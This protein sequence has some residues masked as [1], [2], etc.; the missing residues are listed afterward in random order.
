MD[1]A[2]EKIRPHTNSNLAHQKA[3]ANLLAAVESTFSEQ[4]TDPSP[5]A[6]FAALLT[7]LDST[8]QKRDVSLGDGDILPA[9]LYLLALVAPFVPVPVMRSH[10]NTVLTLTA[11]LFPALTQHAP[12]L[13]SQLSLYNAVLRALDR[14]QLDVQSIRQAFASILQLCIDPR[15]KVRK[16][17]AD[18]V[19]D[20]LESPPA[21]LSRHPYSERV[22][23]W[24]KSALSEANIV[25]FSRAKP[26]KTSGTDSAIHVLAFLRP[27]LPN[28]PASSLP[29]ISNLL[30]SLPR[31][32]NPYLSQSSYSILSDLFALPVEDESIGVNEQISDVLNAVLSSPPSKSDATLSPAWVRVLGTA[33][34]TYSLTDSNAASQEIGRVWKAVFS[35]LESS[36]SSTRTAAAES[37][38]RV[39]GC[40]TPSMIDSALAETDHRSTLGKI[41]TQVTK[42]LNSL[43]YANAIPQ[44]LTV[45]AELILALRYKPDGRTTGAESLLLPLIKHIGDLRIQKG[46]EFKEDAD[47]TL[48]AAMRVL[49]PHVLLGV[50]PLNLEPIDRQEGREP[51][52]YLLPLL[53]QPH[54]SP[55][56]HFVSYFVPL[57]ER[58]FALQQAAEA[59]D[60]QSQAKLWSVL[61]GQIW[62]GLVG[63]CWAPTALK[64]SLNATFSSL[65]S[66]LLYGQAE[67]RPS[68]LKALRVIV[69]SNVAVAS[70][71]TDPAPTNPSGLSPAQ[72]SD[73]VA[74]LRTQAE[75]WLAVLFNVFGT[76]GRD[77]RAVVGDVISAWA[78]VAGEKEIAAAQSKIV[79]LLK[80]NLAAQAAN[81]RHSSIEGGSE[82][83]TTQ[84]LVLLLLPYIS[85]ADAQK[86]FQ[87]CL[88]KTVLCAKDN[89][90]QKRGYKILTR[91]I[92]T[93]KVSIEVET[94]LK[95]LDET[96]EGITPAAKKDRFSLLALLVAQLPSSA[97]H[98]IPS[99]IPEAVLGTKEP[100]EKARDAAFELI[101]DMGKKM[102]QGGVVKRSLVD[103]MEEDGAG[104]TTANIQEFMTMVAGG[105]AGAS[106]HMISATVTAISRLVFEFKDSIPASMH[107]E[108][109]STLF[110]FISSANREIV[111]SILGFVKLA[112]HSLPADLVRPHLPTLVPALLGWSHDHKNHFKVKVRHIFERML[113]RFGWNEVYGYAGEDEAKKVLENIKKRKER[114]KRKKAQA[115]EDEDE[116]TNK[117][118]TG[119]AFEDVLYGSESE[120][121]DSDD[122]EPHQ[123]QRSTGKRRGGESGA[124][125]RIDDDEPMDL[126]QGAASR[127]TQAKSERR[128]KPG[129][130]AARFKT[131]EETGKMLIDGDDDDAE[132]GEDADIAGA[133]YR[134]N[135]TSVDGFTRGANGR[136]KFN[137]DTKKRRRENEDVDGDVEMGDVEPGGAPKSA[138]KAKGRSEAKFGHEFKA[139]KAGGDIKRGGVD[140]YAYM[141]LSQAAKRK[142]GK[143]DKMGIVGK[144]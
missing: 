63:Y 72:A 2:L 46:F 123:Q 74:Y 41:I 38:R 35:Y 131:D 47:V 116:P 143:R 118:A 36:D 108:I 23:D 95:E 33:M 91:L 100:S 45:I 144:R 117:Q 14:S 135:L 64:E 20:V 97:L 124:R 80:N 24:I 16:K 139:K 19:K 52:A 66:G 57:S 48:S 115:N 112:I 27:I 79:Q 68:V 56:S 7:T 110:V 126:L 138:K 22:A 28:L 53:P 31:L 107:S 70:G 88:S 93:K 54:P 55:L 105:L 15:P 42:E 29:A 10:L 87:L 103:G 71:A 98:V 25:P 51:R 140:P 111:K 37:L 76:M 67:L 121:G 9:E 50:L 32:G 89:G 8:I 104:D 129:Q 85:S 5:T 26:S 69:D 40:I 102:A 132:L 17:A 65:L 4:Q 127:I 128:R 62:T 109:L 96:L 92:E 81:P 34:A 106:P 122:D 130:D 137:K 114:A 11:P 141:S 77:N 142:G 78:G 86:L 61:I 94:V 136:V 133:A 90:V 125:I 58:M 101:V 134:E 6:Y 1:R 60:R 119:D 3:P 21:P 49:G 18:V 113:R 75:S 120:L 13:R 99:L 73:N 83:A 82:A 84:D 39:A 44:I 30:L 43:V 59:E 12:V